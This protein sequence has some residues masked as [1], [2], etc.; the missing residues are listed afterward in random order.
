[1]QASFVSRLNLKDLE[2]L[3]SSY[4]KSIVQVSVEFYVQIANCALLHYNTFTEWQ[5]L[6]TNLSNYS[7]HKPCN[8]QISKNCDKRLVQIMFVK[9]DRVVSGVV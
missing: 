3:L 8:S 2:R 7:L 4:S 6:S 5:A 1:M 9:Y